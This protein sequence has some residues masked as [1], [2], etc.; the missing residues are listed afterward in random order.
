MRGE[1]IKILLKAGHYW[2]SSKMCKT[3][4][5]V[6][7]WRADDFPT[8]NASLVVRVSGPILLRNPIFCDFS[9]GGGGVS[10]PP[11]PPSGFAHVLYVPLISKHILANIGVLLY[12]SYSLWNIRFD[13]IPNCI[14]CD[15]VTIPATKYLLNP[16]LQKFKTI[17]IVVCL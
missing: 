12:P 6:F 8:L 1:R 13:F 3:I 4:K 5:M 17:K 7:C 10:G 11:V 16:Q 15:I 9:G 14:L 2:F